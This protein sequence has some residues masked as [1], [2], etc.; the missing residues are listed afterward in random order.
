MLGQL[1]R[2]RLQ[3]KLLPRM[4]VAVDEFLLLLVNNPQ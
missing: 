1:T 3:V 2:H 4:F